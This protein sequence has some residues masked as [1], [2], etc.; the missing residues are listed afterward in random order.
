MTISCCRSIRS[1]QNRRR[2]KS[3]AGGAVDVVTQSSKALIT[4]SAYNFARI[5]IQNQQAGDPLA[6]IIGSSII[7]PLTGPILIAAVANT[8]FR[9]IYP[10]RF[11]SLPWV[12]GYLSYQ[13]R[14][15]TYGPDMVIGA[16]LA[17]GALA[18]IVNIEAVA[19]WALYRGVQKSIKALG[20]DSKEQYWEKRHKETNFVEANAAK[21]LIVTGLFNYA[22]LVY[23]Q[24]YVWYTLPYTVGVAVTAPLTT[25]ML[26][27]SIAHA[28]VTKICEDEPEDNSKQV[29]KQ[30]GKID[31]SCSQ[32][33]FKN[34]KKYGPDVVVFGTL[35]AIFG[36]EGV[37][38]WALYRGAHTLINRL[39][40]YSKTSTMED[41]IEETIKTKFGGDRAAYNKWL[42]PEK[43]PSP[44]WRE[45]V[46][47]WLNSKTSK[48]K[49]KVNK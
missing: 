35:G 18:G 34:V 15:D 47:S 20:R 24:T 25:A 8:S 30:I 48:Q 23:K 42:F 31:P 37:A 32:K 22:V 43:T 45:R 11:H 5:V 49:N 4:T 41:D 16:A 2:C 17:T 40:K 9:T 46:S 26:A 29:G 38:S 19:A 14:K 21:A 36:I 33:L 7:H 44:T 12:W 10:E 3:F 6:Y 39:K 27:S 28:M 1:E 13:V